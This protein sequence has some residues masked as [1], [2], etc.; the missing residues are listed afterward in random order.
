[1]NNQIRLPG[2]PPP[3]KQDIV[4]FYVFKSLSYSTRIILYLSLVLTGFLIQLFMLSPWPGAALLVF[5]TLLN[6]V[7]GYDSRARLKSF[8]T[9]TNWTEVDIERIRQIEKLDDKMSKWD[10]DILDISNSSGVL[11]FVL[12]LTG[13]YIGSGFL[14]VFT[15][16]DVV[17]IITTD[18][19]I[20][21]L[22]LWFNGIRRILKQ[23]N[24]RIKVGIV[25]KMEEFFQVMKKE[26]E[27]FKPSLML[28]RDKSGKSLP[29]DTR[30][31]ITFDGMPADFYGIQAQININLVQGS[32]YPY[33]Y[34]V[35]PAKPGFGLEK[36]VHKIYK[37]KNVT[38]EFQED[39]NA[40]V[41]VIRQFTTK[42]SGYHT[43]IKDC[44]DIL[45]LALT[46]ARIILEG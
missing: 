36:Y 14:N 39:Q 3:E 29:T 5:A 9:D 31:T 30:F 32:S 13:L 33:F 15:G 38:I 44:K 43:K 24:L 8:C 28:A 42:T 27:N 4:R 22:P 12:I 37:A 6:L 45:E 40:E 1:M 21:V 35:I 34:C 18:V 26:G 23:N 25:T 41:I 17:N 7:R 19:V 11:M 2:F 46:N 20:L 10:K 16:S